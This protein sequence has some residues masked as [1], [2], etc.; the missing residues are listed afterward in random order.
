MANARETGGPP[1]VTFETHR[2]LLAPSGDT[3]SMAF[4]GVERATKQ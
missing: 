3:N 2:T 4:D 1:P